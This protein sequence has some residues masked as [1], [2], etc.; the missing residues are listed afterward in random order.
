MGHQL[1]CAAGTYRTQEAGTRGPYVQLRR[2]R[3]VRVN[4]DGLR[5]RSRRLAAQN[6]EQRRIHVL[7]RDVHRALAEEGAVE[8]DDGFVRAVVQRLQLEEDRLAQTRR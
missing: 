2:P 6:I 1:P 7:E 5:Q 8:G 4:P 3:D